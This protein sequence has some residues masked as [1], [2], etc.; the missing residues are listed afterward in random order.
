MLPTSDVL[1][2]PMFLH[3]NSAKPKA[4]FFYFCLCTCRWHDRALYIIFFLRAIFVFCPAELLQQQYYYFICPCVHH[5]YV[6]VYVLFFI[7]LQ[8]QHVCSHFKWPLNM[9]E[10]DFSLV[11]FRMD[12]PCL[13]EGHVSVHCDVFFFY[14]LF[15]CN[16]S[17]GLT[18][19]AVK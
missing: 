14:V 10:E 19:H 4:F 8:R 11:L 5:I 18:W 3:R 16:D 2:L 13:S 6:I 7:I 1:K 15:L 12:H 17:L 9:A